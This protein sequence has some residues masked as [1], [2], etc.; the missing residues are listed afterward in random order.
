MSV[1]AGNST[2][3]T[4]DIDNDPDND[5][6]NSN[7]YY[8]NVK[9]HNV[10]NRYGKDRTDNED[11]KITRATTMKL[12]EKNTKAH[13]TPKKHLGEKPLSKDFF[14]SVLSIFSFLQCFPFL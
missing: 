9:N 6:V 2:G 7:I 1:F 4:I 8:S 12:P 14:P 5:K 3:P 11:F 10:K 13:T